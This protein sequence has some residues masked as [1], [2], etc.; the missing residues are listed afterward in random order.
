MLRRV[1]SALRA[2]PP[3]DRLDEELAR[4]EREAA[5]ATSDYIALLF[6]R[7]GELCVERGDKGRAM[8]C[9]GRAI[10][11]FLD[12]GY[13][14]SAAAMCRRVIELS[15][16]VVRARGTLAFLSLGEGLQYLPFEGKLEENARRAVAE[17]VEAAKRAG[18]E[19]LVGKRLELMASVTDNQ[20]VREMIGEY[21]LEIG[22]PT[23]ADEVLGAVYAERNLLASGPEE[24]QRKRWA[25]ALQA[26]VVDQ[27]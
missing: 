3:A 21:L 25:Q 2:Q 10:D 13:Y 24:D 19:H 20:Q 5:S 6:S 8:R 16:A 11:A 26:S 27:R 9:Y 4:I 14:D 23:S 15:P 7:G 18:V 1:F 17:Y 12:C 22:E